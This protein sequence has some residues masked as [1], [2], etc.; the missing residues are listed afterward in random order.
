MPRLVRK[1]ASVGVDGLD[2]MI[3]SLYAGGMTVREIRHHLDST[4]GVDLSAGTISNITDAVADTV[5]QWR[6]RPLEEFYSVVYLDAIRVKVCDGGRMSNRAAHIAVG[7]D[8]EGVTHVLGIWVQADEGASLWAAVCAELVN[9]GV[10]DVLIVCCDGLTGLA[11]AVEATWPDSLV[12]T[13]LVHLIRSSMRFVSYGDCKKV[14]AALTPIYTVVNEDAAPG[15]LADFASSPLG[16]ALSR[17]RGGLAEGLAKIRA[18][19]SL[20]A[21]RRVIYTTNSTESL[22]Y[23]LRKVTN[24]PR[25][26][27]NDAAAI[28]LLW[29]AICNIEDRRTAKRA[30]EADTAANKRTA[31]ARLIQ[32]KTTNDWKQAPTQLTATYPDHINP[33]L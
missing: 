28:K 4:L 15:A 17:R 5:L 13:C 32:A 10:R 19:P 3:I 2:G 33:Y 16:G 23:Q 31:K 8:M 30:K 14:A 11:E 22:N 9:R 27:P 7:V 1:G 12:Q 24:N 29:L 20:P 26:F 6:S 18:V 25:H 21:V